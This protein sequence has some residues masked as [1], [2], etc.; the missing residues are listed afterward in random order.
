[1]FMRSSYR[2]ADL[3]FPLQSLRLV[4][5]EQG[6]EYREVIPA[7]VFAARVCSSAL[8]F[9]HADRCQEEGDWIS[10]F[11]TVIRVQR[12]MCLQVVCVWIAAS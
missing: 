5:P 9:G 4:P 1:M 10:L 11:R 6:L 2:Q 7:E 8:H 12:S 3:P